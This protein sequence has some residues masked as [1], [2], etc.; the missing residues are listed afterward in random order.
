[1]DT[2]HT[3]IHVSP[4]PR[5]ARYELLSPHGDA[6]TLLGV[7]EEWLRVKQEQ[8]A[9]G[10]SAKVGRLRCFDLKAV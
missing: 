9:P 10:G 6:I 4:N 7:F 1:M 2:P 3:H 5:E 8:R